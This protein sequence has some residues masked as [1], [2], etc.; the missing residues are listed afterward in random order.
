[1]LWFEKHY[2]HFIKLLL[3]KETVIIKYTNIGSNITNRI[4]PYILTK[5]LCGNEDDESLTSYEKQIRMIAQ[6]LVFNNLKITK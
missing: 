3:N 5:F 1:M 4:K 6:N 2:E